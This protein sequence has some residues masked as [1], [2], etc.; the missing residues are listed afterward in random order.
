MWLRAAFHSLG[1]DGTTLKEAK[2]INLS[3]HYLEQVI[4]ALQERSMGLAR[5]GLACCNVAHEQAGSLETRAVVNQQQHRLH[6]NARS[7]VNIRCLGCCVYCCMCI[8]CMCR[9]ATA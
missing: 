6:C 8:G 3:L 7:V 4:I 2:Y 9:T 5:S 1:V